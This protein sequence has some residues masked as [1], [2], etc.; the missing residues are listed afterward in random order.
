MIDPQ[1]LD[2]LI[3]PA[4]KGSVVFK[5]DKIVCQGCKRRYP[6]ENG[7]PVMIIEAAESPKQKEKDD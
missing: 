2:I 1:L 7:I 3:C 5:D 6:V 4:C